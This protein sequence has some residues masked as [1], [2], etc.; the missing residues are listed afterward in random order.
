MPQTSTLPGASSGSGINAGQIELDGIPLTLRGPLNSEIINVFS[1]GVNMGNPG[2]NNHPTNSSIIVSSAQGGGQIWKVNPGSDLQ[3]FWWATMMTE[4]PEYITLAPYTKDYLAPI[5][6]AGQILG[7]YPNGA[8]AKLYAAA[9]GRLLRYTVGSDSFTDLMAMNAPATGHKGCN[10]TVQTGVN[11]GNTYMFIPQTT[12]YQY[13]NGAVLSAAVTELALE[14]AVWDDKL[15]MLTTD[16]K[17]KWTLDGGI[18]WNTVAQIPDGSVPTH[19]LSFV[20]RAD[21]PIIYV[22]TNNFVW[23]LNFDAQMLIKTKLYSPQ[24]PTSGLAAEYHNAD[25][26]YAAGLGVSLYNLQT[27]SPVGLDRDQGLPTEFRGYI[28]DMEG[29]NNGLFALVRGQTAGASVLETETLD[30][31]GGDDPMYSGSSGVNSTLMVLGDEGWHYRWHGAGGHDHRN[32][33]PGGV[34]SRHRCQ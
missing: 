32:R 5:G 23:A 34:R 4:Y 2:P 9:A 10:Y 25:L 19:I 7:D 30:V 18:N 3:R 24:H 8:T 16:G 1:Q 12:Q 27:I 21:D 28:V 14:F 29:S 17:V 31:G 22:V 13:W 6:A 11:A 33:R 20:N 15:F 26:Y